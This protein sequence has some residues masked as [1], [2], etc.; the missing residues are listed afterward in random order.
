MIKSIQKPK[1]LRKKFQKGYEYERTLHLIQTKGLHTVCQEANCPNI[2]ECFSKKTAT[3]LILGDRCTRNCSFCN[4]QH[5]IPKSIN[6]EEPR[7]VALAAAALNLSYVVVTSVTRDDLSD[8]GASSFVNTIKAIK[9]N[10]SNVNIEVLVPDFNG[11]KSSIVAVLDGQPDVF[12]HNIETARRF[13]RFVRPQADY[14][15][16]L[17]L[18]ETAAKYSPKIIIKSGL[19]LGMG[20]KERDIYRTIKDLHQAGV[21]ILTIGQYLQ[22]T[23]KHY[24]VHGYIAPETFNYWKTVAIE[25]GFFEASCGTFVRSSYQAKEKFTRAVCKQLSMVAI[26]YTKNGSFKMGHQGDGLG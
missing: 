15:R 18:L 8:G 25:M 16:S 23:S 1:W 11:I 7:N 2:F 12:N 5:G 17:S 3:F 9:E 14:D 10:I 19:M 22:P 13:Y 6:H 21:N 24:P 26:K 20:E 4:I